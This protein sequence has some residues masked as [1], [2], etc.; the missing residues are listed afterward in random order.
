MFSRYCLVLR[1][2]C[3]S[4]DFHSNC[5]YPPLFSLC[6]YQTYLIFQSILKNI[7]IFSRSIF[8]D[9]PSIT[10]R[11]RPSVKRNHRQDHQEDN[12]IC[13]FS[14][15]A[16][17][18]EDCWIGYRYHSKNRSQSFQILLERRVISQDTNTTKWSAPKEAQAKPKVIIIFF[19]FATTMSTLVP[20]LIFDLS[21]S[22][23]T[24][25]EGE[26]NCACPSSA[27]HHTASDCCWPDTASTHWGTHFH[28]IPIK[29][30]F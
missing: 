16:W 23:R 24:A 15:F 27:V 18:T 22:N 1:K 4:I 21:D 2:V 9:G 8:A 19:L 25:S 11:R 14:F 10:W 28:T 26:Y 3:Y 6:A 12:E 17:T 29:T 7:K 5:L 20:N 13:R 30:W